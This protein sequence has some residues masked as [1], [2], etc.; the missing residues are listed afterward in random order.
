MGRVDHIRPQG[1]RRKLQTRPNGLG[2][3]P[4]VSLQQLLY[5]FAR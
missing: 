2:R 3:E 4:R 5:R 1:L